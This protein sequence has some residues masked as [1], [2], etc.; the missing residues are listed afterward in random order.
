MNPNIDRNFSEAGRW[1]EE[2]E[3]ST[4]D[5][6][7]PLAQCFANTK[8]TLEITGGTATPIAALQVDRPSGR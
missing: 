2:L 3:H 5:T 7:I 8:H 1:R 6:T 4:V